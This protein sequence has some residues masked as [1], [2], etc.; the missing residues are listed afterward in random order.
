MNQTA[1]EKHVWMLIAGMIGLFL[2]C[3]PL[4]IVFF[5]VNYDYTLVTVAMGG[6][7][8]GLVT[9]ALGVFAVL[10]QESL[11]GDS[12]SHAALPGVAIAFLIAGRDLPW[13]LVG[14][15]IA[16]WIGVMMIKGITSTTRL[17]Q[18]AALG[19]TLASFFAFGIAL[20]TYIQSRPDAS[21]AGLDQFIFG[22]A[23][24][25]IRQ[26]VIMMSIVTLVVFAMI[27]L[28]WKEFKLIA[29]DTEFASA[30]GFAVRGLETLLSTL[31]V[32][33]IVLGL[34]LAGVILMVGM[35]IG[36]AVA[37]RQW[38]RNLGQMIVLAGVFGAF[39]GSTGA[40]L[41]AITTGL[42]TGPLIIVVAV[43]LV[44]I[45]ISFAPGRG[46]VWTQWRQRQNRQRFAAQNI[47]QD[48]YHHAQQH[49]DLGYPAPTGT[50]VA[51]RGKAAHVGLKSLT[52][53]GLIAQA[54][55]QKQAW[56][57]TPQGVQAAQ[58]NAYNHHLWELYRQ[59]GEDLQLPM[60]PEAHQEDI[61]KLLPASALVHLEALAEG[62][63]K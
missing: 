30:N 42:P 11:M 48:I 56:K 55:P 15:G 46:I 3:I 10:R 33:A 41:S 5:N 49:N 32:I 1:E 19:I 37:A 47:L 16:G 61:R 31:I 6:A 51:L 54:N 17:K 23:A 14:A 12:L 9:G 43:T 13:L 28:F 34:Q 8:L 27:A 44:F 36:P 45:S 40:I 35:L 22:Q 29:F 4:S 53:D 63:V 59:Y 52:N 20:L 2:L 38:T 24:S 60:I 58:A 39:S 50:L 18:D 62:T 21:Q 57:L 7:L 26:N 25:I